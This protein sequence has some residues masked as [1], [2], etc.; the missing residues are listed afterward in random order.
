MQLPG[1]TLPSMGPLGGSPPNGFLGSRA[2][3]IRI[4]RITCSLASFSARTSPLEALWFAPPA[5]PCNHLAQSHHASHALRFLQIQPPQGQSAIL[6]R[7]SALHTCQLRF[8]ALESAKSC[9][10]VVVFVFSHL[11]LFFYIAHPHALLR[12]RESTMVDERAALLQSIDGE[13]AGKF[14]PPPLSRSS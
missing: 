2:N 13:T 1:R 5:I 3:G 4:Y 12:C 14:S 11:I 8:A 6:A 7:N 9:S 10:L